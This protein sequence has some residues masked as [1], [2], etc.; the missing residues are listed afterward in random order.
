[1]DKE[2]LLY[3]RPHC[4]LCVEAY[5]LLEILQTEFSFTIKEVNIDE[6]DEL[7]EKYGLYIPVIEIDGEVIQFGQIDIGRITQYLQKLHK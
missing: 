5:F 3:S 6:S 2:V 4:H 1:M 7:T